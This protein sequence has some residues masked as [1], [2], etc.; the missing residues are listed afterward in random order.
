[1]KQ[2]VTKVKS[3]PEG[4]LVARPARETGPYV[5]LMLDRNF[6]LFFGSEERLDLLLALLQ[7]FLPELGIVS[8]EL[9]DKENVS[10]RKELKNS[11]F[12][13]K[14]K[15]GD[16]R[17][18]IVEAQYNS[19]PDYLDRVL[20]YSY[21]PVMGQ[22]RSGK[23]NNY[24]LSEVYVLSFTNFALVHDEDWEGD[25]VSSYSLREDGNGEL[26][27]DA[28]HFRYV[29]LGR[30]GK[31]EA[32]LESL[33]DR[34]LYYLKNL[35]GL[36]EELAWKERGDAIDRLVEAARV[37]ALNDEDR[38]LYIRN[39]ESAFDIQSEIWYARQEGEARGEAKGRAEGAS[40]RTDEIA[41]NLKADGVSPE[42]VSRYTGLTPEQVQAL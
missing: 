35:G 30:F 19:R 7:E 33:R 25:V 24:K 41:R 2:F 28:L 17:T 20:Y 12:D 31:K 38:D 13:V 32:E 4:E 14:C 40:V 1:M 29:E 6:K 42:L 18:V 9:G 3:V 10:M 39:M 21:W 15:L 37:Q 36:K 5:E 8:V 23:K 26:M 22:I 11:V 16:G 34:W 27:T